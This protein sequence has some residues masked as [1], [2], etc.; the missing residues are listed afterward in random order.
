VNVLVERVQHAAEQIT[1]RRGTPLYRVV[2]AVLGTIAFF[3]V[4]ESAWEPSPGSYFQGVTVGALYGLLGVGI[5]LIYRTNRII[6][7]A[8]AALGAV[9]AIS[10]ALFMALKGMSWWLAFPLAIVWA[11]VMGLLIDVVIVRRFDKSPRLILTVA[12]IGISQILAYFGLMMPFWLGNEALVVSY[13]SPFTSWRFNLGRTVFS[14]DYIFALGVIALAALGLSLFL[15]YTRIGIAL[16]ASAENA[17]R[18]ALLGIPV[19]RV[20]AVAWTIAAVLAALAIFA[21]SGVVGVPVDGSLGPKVLLFALTAAIVARMDN[22]LTCVVAGCALGIMAATSTAHEGSDSF[23]AGLMVFIVVAALLLQRKQMARALDTGVS[24]WQ[25]VREFRALP[26]ELAG[27]P[28]VRAVRVSLYVVMGVVLLALPYVVGKGR[29]GYANLALIS[30]IVAVSLVVLSGWAGQISLGHFGIAGVGAL[31][32]GQLGGVHN[33]DFFLV[34]LVG[35]AAGALVAVL[36]GVPALRIPGLYLG[37][38]TLAFAGA[39]ELVFLDRHFSIGRLLMPPSATQIPVPVLWGRIRL[40]DD[41][42]TSASRSYYYLILVLL[43]IAVLVARSYRNSRAGRSVLAIRENSRAASSYSIN[44]SRT[45]LAAF[46]VSG[47]IAAMAGVLHAYQ[48]NGVDATTYGISRSIGIFVF[49]AIGGLTSI[50]G[51]VLGTILFDSIRLYGDDYVRNLSLLVSGPGLLLVLLFLPG[52]LAEGFY[53]LRDRWLRRLA[54]K[55]EILVPSLVADRRVDTVEESAV[56]R[57]E[58]HVESADGFDVL[59][60]RRIT[61]PVCEQTFPIDEAPEHEHLRVGAEL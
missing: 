53:R 48:S 54:L 28:A 23:V 13:R 30:A 38:A 19:K 26:K 58:E 34:L 31:V 59:T 50:G 52:G 20:E 21:R 49:T 61:C 14:G 47:G 6:N 9:P 56:S 35:I 24:S 55:H 25:S 5:I 1:S 18:A 57:A 11:A 15:R 41:L 44:P 10:C 12:T 60:E 42:G 51:A 22:M 32:A 7:F 45:K 37:V 29:V 4:V 17:D 3:F 16:R 40:T 43:G 36:L 39:M 27:L 33:L 2:S 46:A 8:A